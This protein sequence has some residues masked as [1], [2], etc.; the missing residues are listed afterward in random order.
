MLRVDEL[1]RP[2]VL[3]VADEP[4]IADALTVALRHVGYDAQS[5]Y[6]GTSALETAAT[7]SPDLLL[8]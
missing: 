3:V 4:H 5:A 7:W 8:L 2:R 6:D 1:A